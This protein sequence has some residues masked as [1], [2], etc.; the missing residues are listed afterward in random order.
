MCV[1]DVSPSESEKKRKPPPKRD[2]S[3][4]FFLQGPL[5]KKNV[6]VKKVCA[7]KVSTFIFIALL[8]KSYNPLGSCH[9]NTNF[10]LR[11]DNKTTWEKSKNWNPKTCRYRSDFEPKWVFAYFCFLFLK[12]ILIFSLLRLF[13][14]LRHWFCFI[15]ELLMFDFASP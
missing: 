10:H 2:A 3:W 8:L 12:Y 1:W 14:I 6:V 5:K 11:E 7:S 4:D 15:D 9:P 13:L